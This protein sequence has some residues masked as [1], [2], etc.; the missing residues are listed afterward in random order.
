MNTVVHRSKRKKLT[1][2]EGSVSPIHDGHAPIGMILLAAG[3]L[4]EIDVNR[5]MAAQRQKNLRFGEA[6]ERLGLVSNEDVT[7]ALA[8]QFHYPYVTSESRLDPSLIA[9]YRPFS[10]TAENLR[11]LRSQLLLRWFDDHQPNTLAVVSPR[12]RSG[13]SHLAANL[14]IVFAQLGERTLLID[15]NLRRPVQH[16][17]F[18]L[19]SGVGLSNVLAGRCELGDALVRVEPF[20][21]LK[22]LGAGT[23]PP[24][25][26]ELLGRTTFRYLLE[27]VPASFDVV[28]LDT[29]PI[30]EY[31][32]AQIIAAASGGCLVAA[33]RHKTRLADVQQ[34]KARI[35]P[36]QATVLGTALVG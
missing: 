16:A 28:I 34:A 8:Q 2:S 15:A 9:A 1:P 27:T 25:P 21:Q 29:P 22:V 4:T 14:A 13:C 11:E 33:R 3:K 30:L 31:A 18:S 5:V 17:L 26:Q 36:T 23:T 12:R 7:Q 10:E 6:A 19:P 35:A 20:E 32:D 24:N